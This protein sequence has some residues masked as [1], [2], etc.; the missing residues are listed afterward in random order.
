MGDLTVYSSLDDRYMYLAEY[1]LMILTANFSKTLFVVV[2]MFFLFYRLVSRHLV[3]IASEI[4]SYNQGDRPI[5]IHLNRKSA[6]NKD[7]L[8]LVVESINNLQQRVF[9]EQ[10][11]VLNESKQKEL[12]HTQVIDQKEKLIEL[13][14]N[15]GLNEFALSLRVEIRKPLFKLRVCS[16]L[17]H[18]QANTIPYDLLA[19][20][21]GLEDISK[22]ISHALAVIDRSNDLFKYNQPQCTPVNINDSIA[23]TL[24]LLSHNLQEASVMVKHQT[25]GQYV[26]A[27]VDEKHIEQVLVS[28]VRNAIE[29]LSSAKNE[30]SII[31]ISAFKRGGNVV[32]DIADNG[33]GIDEELVSQ[34]FSPYYTTKKNG[35]GIGLSISKNLVLEMGGTMTATNNMI[36]LSIVIELPA[37]G[38]DVSPNSH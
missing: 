16:E 23:N 8:D 31:E 5:R 35:L 19:I 27:F 2:F 12:L 3:R 13:E 11:K 26:M 18:R 22:N 15:I 28:I 36:G 6:E 9:F 1:G 33:P 17:V 32:I 30:T 7:E 4:A 10:S 25:Q 34:I 29:A 24:M 38:L 14:R 20:N 37:N 21:N